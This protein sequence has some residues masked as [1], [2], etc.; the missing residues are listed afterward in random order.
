MTEI[1]REARASGVKIQSETHTDTQPH[2]LVYA[3][4]LK[5]LRTVKFCKCRPN[6]N[7]WAAA[8]ISPR[9]CSSNSAN[10]SRQH[11][12]EAQSRSGPVLVCVLHH[13]L[14]LN[15]LT[16]IPFQKFC[17][18][19]KILYITLKMREKKNKPKEPKLKKV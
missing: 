1:P 5:S 10:S 19:C 4:N 17:L 12:E 16:A 11:G 15:L 3:E 7:L 14:C 9:E 6:D 13:F 8:Q 2:T 18:R